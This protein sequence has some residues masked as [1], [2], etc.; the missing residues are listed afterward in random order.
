MNKKTIE[1]TKKESC[2]L[3]VILLSE[4]V[5]TLGVLGEDRTLELLKIY[6]KVCFSKR[7][8][9][10]LDNVKALLDEVNE[11]LK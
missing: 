5:D 11:I 1:I 10:T 6:N 2:I 7:E 8:E 9:I 3:R 4:M